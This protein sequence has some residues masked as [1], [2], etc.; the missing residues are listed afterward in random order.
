MAD[1]LLRHMDA[2]PSP[3]REKHQLAFPVH[4]QNWLI[5][6]LRLMSFQREPRLRMT[7]LDTLPP[8]E[9]QLR[10]TVFH[11]SATALPI[12][13]R[14]FLL[15]QSHSFSGSYGRPELTCDGLG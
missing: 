11:S 8:S 13:L 1:P 2:T 10:K 3:S 12:A 7:G 9:S 14:L 15:E 4:L 6:S 5:Q